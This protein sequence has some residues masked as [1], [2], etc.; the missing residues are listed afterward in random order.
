MERPSTVS[1]VS[2]KDP[3]STRR[4]GF[5]LVELLAV[6]MIIALLAALVTPSVMRSM[7]SARAAAVKVE[8]DLLHTAVMNYKNEYGAFPPADMRGLWNDS[9]NT[10]N[11][12]HPAYKHLKRAF[13][14]LNEPG[15]TTATLPSQSPY[16]YMAQMSPAQALVFWLQG[17]YENPQFPLTNGIALGTNAPRS[18]DANGSRKKMFDFDDK[19]L[20][21]ASP[22]FNAVASPTWGNAQTFFKRNDA[23]TALAR[24][25]PVYFPNIPN[26]GVPY[27]YFPSATY[28]SPPGGPVT[29]AISAFGANPPVFYY[30]AASTTGDTSYVSPYFNSSPPTQPSFAQLHANPETFQLISG[31]ADGIYAAANTVVASFPVGVPSFTFNS[32]A[33]GPLPGVGQAAGNEDNITNFAGGPLKAAAEKLQS[34]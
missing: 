21:A 4:S 30:H 34:Q 6:I 15:L 33:I 9:T 5:T 16:Y 26:A 7:S 29:S 11:T 12:S 22:Y 13:P 19:R 3:S 28:S 17:F 25:Y 18:G 10:V 8:I 31:G 24:D 20:Y 27:T 14:R 2:P 32:Q 23:P 1:S